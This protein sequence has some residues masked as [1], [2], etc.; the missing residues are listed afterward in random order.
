MN[1]T[2][3]VPQGSIL[4]PLL[5]LVYINNIV[6]DMNSTIHLFADDTG[7]CIVVDSP[8]EASDKLNQGLEKIA[9]WTD[10]WLVS[11]NPNKTE[12]MICSRKN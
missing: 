1:L 6:N 2:V 11:F 9:A 10:M 5:L 4:G 8:Q 3:G 7:Q 12:P